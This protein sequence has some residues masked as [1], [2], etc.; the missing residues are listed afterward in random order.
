MKRLVGA[1]V[2]VASGLFLGRVAFSQL[3]WLPLFNLANIKVNCSEAIKV[4]DV[5]SYSNLRL[6][7]SIFKQDLQAAG[8]RLLRLPGIESVSLKRRLPKTV[9]INVVSD[10]IELLAKTKGIRCL[11]STLKLVDMEKSMAILPIVT[12]LSPTTRPGYSDRRK[13]CY[14]LAIYDELAQQSPNLADRLSEIH[15]NENDTAELFFNPGGARVI[16]ALRNCR[17]AV[18]RL[19]VLDTNGILGN[20]GF[21]DMTAGR[22]V[23]EGGTENDKE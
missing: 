14:S 18:G 16:I 7:S 12:G 21:F 22:M 6:G 23:V 19:V 13:L 17:Q 9:E 10:K 3:E 15:M 20:T 5:L 4:E 2:V 11:T 8:E 1:M